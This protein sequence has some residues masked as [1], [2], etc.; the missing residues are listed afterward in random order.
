MQI[1]IIP[2]EDLIDL[3]KKVNEFLKSINDEDPKI[4]IDFTH[5]SALVR[6]H[7]RD[8]KRLCCDCIHFDGDSDTSSPMGLCQICGKRVRFNTKSC[9]DFNDIRG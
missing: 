2:S 7:E 3:E 6:Y 5:I 1:K 8:A 4:E 9:K